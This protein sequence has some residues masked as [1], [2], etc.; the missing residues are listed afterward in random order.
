[1][2]NSISVEAVNEILREYFPDTN[3]KVTQAMEY[4]LFS[5]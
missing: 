5:L 3:D 1:M 4:S 2:K